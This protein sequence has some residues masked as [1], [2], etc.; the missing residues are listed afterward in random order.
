MKRLMT[1]SISGLKCCPLCAAT[2][3][4]RRT[5]NA[6]GGYGPRLLQ[7]LGR[8]F[9][10]AKLEVNVCAKCGHMLLFADAEPRK[11]LEERFGWERVT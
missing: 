1:R 10:P 11:A 7:G 2:T 6:N 9:R 5:V 3:L 4:Y 8:L